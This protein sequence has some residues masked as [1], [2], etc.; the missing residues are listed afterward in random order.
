MS[1][2]H[3]LLNDNDMYFFRLTRQMICVPT[4]MPLHIETVVLL[5]NGIIDSRKVKVDMSLEDM[6]M[7]GFKKGSTYEA[8]KDYVK[9]QTGYKVSSLYIVQVKAIEDALRHFQMI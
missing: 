5:S 7:S 1:N 2:N 3:D 8:I 9:E 6:D 4:K